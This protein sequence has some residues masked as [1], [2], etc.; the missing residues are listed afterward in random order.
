MTMSQKIPERLILKINYDSRF[1]MHYQKHLNA[2]TDP[3][4]ERGKSKKRNAAEKDC[5]RSRCRF[6]GSKRI[7]KTLK[8]ERCNKC[9]S[10]NDNCTDKYG[11]YKTRV[12]TRSLHIRFYDRP[13]P[14]DLFLLF[15]RH[16]LRLYNVFVESRKK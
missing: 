3:T 7:Y 14:R 5:V 11:S 2:L 8:E 6:C 10:L 9:R 4:D 16:K 1:G 12:A 15:R 13:R